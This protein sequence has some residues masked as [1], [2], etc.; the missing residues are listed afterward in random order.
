M[1]AMVAG[2]RTSAATRLQNRL[3]YATT[4]DGATGFARQL[5]P[6]M[7]ARGL[8]SND[9]RR[10][11]LEDVERCIQEAHTLLTRAYDILYARKDWD[12]E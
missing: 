11:E 7:M 3:T 12:S 6:R 2:V 10:A 4:S 9:P 5:E 8:S 1:E